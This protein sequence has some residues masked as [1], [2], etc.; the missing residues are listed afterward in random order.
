MKF[1]IPE[2]GDEIKLTADWH[3]TLYVEDR[4]KT[5]YP[6]LLKKQYPTQLEQ[7]TRIEVPGLSWDK[8]PRTIVEHHLTS[9]P[10]KWVD[11]GW[12]NLQLKKPWEGYFEGEFRV[13]RAGNM[14]VYFHH[15][16]D[17]IPVSLPAGTV[18]M[19]DRIYIR[20]GREDW[21]S[22][23]FKVPKG[24]FWAK[25]DEVNNM[26][27]EKIGHTSMYEGRPQPAPIGG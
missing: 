21:S 1:Y 19:V 23:T 24:R 3:F 13:Y 4:N 22:V 16:K 9:D 2:I 18:L 7:L 8:T 20:Q 10:T 26:E 27:F 5:M 15:I 14:E 6:K 12:K 17:S 25:L 11:G